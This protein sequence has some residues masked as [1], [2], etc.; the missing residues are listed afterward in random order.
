M[1]FFSENVRINPVSAFAVQLI[2]IQGGPFDSVSTFVSVYSVIYR[3]YFLNT[4]FYIYL[5]FSGF[6][7][8]FF[9]SCLLSSLSLAGLGLF[10]CFFLQT[11]ELHFFPSAQTF[12]LACLACT[13]FCTPVSYVHTD[14]R[15]VRY[16]STLCVMPE[17]I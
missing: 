5:C 3:I 17:A 13:S 7:V 4:F 15:C 11:N 2:K 16:T 9:F 1:I 6:S 14:I 8:V 10:I 12:L